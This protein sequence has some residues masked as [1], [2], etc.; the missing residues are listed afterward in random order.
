MF[1]FC[2]NVLANLLIFTCRTNRK[3]TRQ[4]VF[5]EKHPRFWITFFD[6]NRRSTLRQAQNSNFDHTFQDLWSKSGAGATTFENLAR[7]IMAP[8]LP[9]QA[10]RRQT[11]IQQENKLRFNMKA[12]DKNIKKHCVCAC[13]RA[14]A[15]IHD[16]KRNAT[17]KANP[18]E[19]V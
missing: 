19:Y 16:I 17:R 14:H 10:R 18:N 8:K 1:S 13:A 2:W 5:D 9:Q 12:K 6:L 3:I 15:K 7:R 4:Y 11:S